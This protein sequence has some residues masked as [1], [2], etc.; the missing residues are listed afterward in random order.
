MLRGDKISRIFVFSISDWAWYP[1]DL[2]E[3][4]AGTAMPITGQS[5][6][7]YVQGRTIY[8]FSLETKRWSP[9][10][11]P[12][13]RTPV[14]TVSAGAIKVESDGHVNEFSGKTGIWTQTRI[15]EVRALVDAAIKAAE[16]EE[17][18]SAEPEE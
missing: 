16:A 13:G 5:V 10:E 7:A 11:L 14:P 4:V 8:A 3:P 18:D 15:P 1:L 17:K 9:L 6:A 12:E 2:R